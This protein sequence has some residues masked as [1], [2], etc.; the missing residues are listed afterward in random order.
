MASEPDL[1]FESDTPDPL[2]TVLKTGNG[3]KFPVKDAGCMCERL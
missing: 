3:R 2:K 1:A